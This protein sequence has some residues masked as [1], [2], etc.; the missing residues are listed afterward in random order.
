MVWAMPR[1]APVAKRV[2]VERTVHGHTVVDDYG[3]LRD[4]EDPEVISYLEAENA[5][6]ESATAHTERLREHLFEEIKGRILET[7]VTVPAPKGPWSYYTRTVE[8]LQYGIHCRRPGGEGD[9]DEQVLVDFNDVASGHEY[10]GVGAFA[11]SPDHRLVAYSVDFEGDEDHTIRVKNLETGEHEPDEIPGT[12]YGVAWAADGATFFY[13]TIDEARRPYRLWRHRLGT[14]PSDDELIHEEKDE[15]F[16]LGVG[17]TRSD[18]YVVMSLASKLTSEVWVLPADE[19]AGAFRVIEP[20]RHGVEYHVEHQ[21][22]R[23]LILTNEDA[24]NFRLMEAPTASP[25][26]A[27][28]TELIAHREDTRL[29]DVDAFAGHLVVTFRRDAL[30]GLRVLRLADGD[31]HEVEFPEAVYDVSGGD[32]L[33]Y[34]TTTFRLAYTSL[35]TPPSIYD[36]DLDARTLTLRKR[37]PVLGGYDPDEYESLRLWAT[38]ADGERIPISLV[39][40]KGA[41]RDGSNRLLL[42]GYG[43]YEISSDPWFSA[44]RLSLLERGWVFAIAHVRGG[45]EMGR[46]WYEAGKLLAKPN[47]FSDYI[48]CAEQLVAE[49]WTNA[50]LLAGEGA[51]AGGLLIGAVANNAPDRFRALVAEVPFVDALNSMLDPTL[52]LTVTEWEEWGNPIDDEDV[53]RTMYAYSPY[54][55]VEAKAHPAILATAGLYDPRVLYHEPAKWVAKLRAT[56]TQP[57]DRPILLKTQLHAGHAGPS[58]RYDAWREAAF[59]LA[60]LLDQVGGA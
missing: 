23:F 11:V 41:A 9:D 37:Q 43:S 15:R 34:D 58:G 32:N 2:P 19:P 52:P 54:E 47:T 25:G 29:E 56:A 53:Y 1:E 45:G 5:H 8:G 36:Y 39:H 51:S 24:E 48:A 14:P 46:R 50:A 49:G 28:W 33:E 7:D 31:V 44:A 55:N 4:R 12:Y 10:L 16:W 26:R 3:W 35:V 21:G 27:G 6:T 13:T 57:D 42:Y 18:A 40:P 38:A 20:R 59:K 17:S 22:N 60:F 30:H